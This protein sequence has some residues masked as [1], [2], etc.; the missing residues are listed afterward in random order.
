MVILVIRLS[1]D[2]I[3]YADIEKNARKE[4]RGLWVD[5]NPLPPC[6]WRKL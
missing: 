1:A 2:R 4:Q 5:P 6:K 3:T